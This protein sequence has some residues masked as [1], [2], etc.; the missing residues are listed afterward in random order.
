MNSLDGRERSSFHVLGK[1]FI[2]V[3]VV[4]ASAVSFTL[5]FFVGKSGHDDRTTGAALVTGIPSGEGRAEPG[6][7]GFESPGGETANAAKKESDGVNMDLNTPKEGGRNGGKEMSSAG[8]PGSQNAT[9]A[10]GGAPVEKRQPAGKSEAGPKEKASSIPVLEEKALSGEI[11][12]A[13]QLGAFRNPK[14]AEQFAEGFVEKGFKPYITAS[15]TKNQE[16]IFKVKAGEFKDRKNAEILSLK[17]K[18][19]E[20]LNAFVTFKHE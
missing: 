18:K 16:K 19:T 8:V 6:T 11:L 2:I 10:S 5:G 7:S 20:G 12:Y 4:L 14:E 1:E 3:I 9:P 13:V 15:R 17:I